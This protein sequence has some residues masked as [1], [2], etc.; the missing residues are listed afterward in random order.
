[1]AAMHEVSL[2]AEH[3]LDLGGFPLTNTVAATALTVV[4]LVVF[5]VIVRRGAGVVP[6]RLQMLVELIFVFFMDQ[7]TL[8]TGSEKMARRL[9]PFIVTLFLFI[10]VGNLFILLPLV[11]S[12]IVHEGHHVVPALRT[13]TT[14][15]S[16]TIGMAFSVIASSHILAFMVSPLGHLGN[17]IRIGGFFKIKKPLDVLTAFIDVFLG[18]LEG[19]SEVAKI[20]SL[21]TRLFGNI[22]AGEVV[23]MIVMGLMSWTA[24]LVPIP[25]IFLAS[26]AG[27]VQAFVFVLLSTLFLSANIRHASHAH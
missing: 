25:F 5:A 7:L 16:A 20:F 4:L 22:F 26:M 19:I 1:M 12:V 2:A 11:S 15:Y 3:I 13:P 6:S 17:Y 23:I 27:V 24:Y 14:D 8:A 21:G 9:A 10:F 18:L